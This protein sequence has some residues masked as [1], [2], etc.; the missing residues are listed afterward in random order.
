MSK[1]MLRSTRVGAIFIVAYVFV[2]L[3]LGWTSFYS[4]PMKIDKAASFHQTVW[5][6]IT[7]KGRSGADPDVLVRIHSARVLFPALMQI[8][9]F[10][11]LSPEQ[12]FSLVRLISAIL[13]LVLFHWL[14]LHWF[15]DELAF[16]GTLFM[17]AT[18][19]LTFNQWYELPTDFL[20]II[21]FT[22]GVWAIYRSKYV[23]LCIVT[24]LGT[25]NRESTAVLPFF[26]FFTLFDLKKFRWILPVA[27]AGFCWLIPLLFLRWWV[28]ALEPHG[29]GLGW[30]H[31]TTGLLQLF[32]NP[33]PYNN[34]LFWIYLF[35][36]FWVLPYL[37]WREQ[38][39]FFKRL[40]LAV[41]VM[42]VVYLIVGGFLDEPR[43]LVNL[44][45]VLVPAGLVA[46]FPESLIADRG[47]TVPLRTG[48]TE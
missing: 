23:A 26:L 12:A 27:A 18:M 34:Y 36:A 9:R 4:R 19:P 1:Q 37:K 22:I 43:E 20:E 40:L 48:L 11:G 14:L 35:G 28:G 5:N 33:H 42:V 46:L 24:F 31:N 21:I 41:P 32:S 15:T 16:C 3:I 10:A 39:V 45:P 38:P 25:F 13:A 2:G 8:P 17:A 44:Y 30:Q 47:G 29:Y 6:N 7:E